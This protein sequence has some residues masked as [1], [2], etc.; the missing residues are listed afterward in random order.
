MTDDTAK[1]GPEGNGRPNL[2]LD[3]DG[4]GIGKVEFCGIDIGHAV[5]GVTI[6]AVAGK[7]VSLLL[8]MAAGWGIDVDGQ[9]LADLRV[10]QAPGHFDQYQTG[11]AR[12]EG[13]AG[14]GE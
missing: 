3:I 5:Q 1:A 8:Q 14:D 12:E 6:V 9:V 7:P 13:S 11:A 2:R 4:R 10:T